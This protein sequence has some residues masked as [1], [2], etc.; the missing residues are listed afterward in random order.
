VNRKLATGLQIVFGFV[1]GTALNVVIVWAGF[2]ASSLITGNVALDQTGTYGLV[3]IG[4]SQLIWQV[5]VILILRRK[6]H[7]ALALG[8][9]LAASVTAL[10]NATCWGLMWSGKIK[11]GG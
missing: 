4:V 8:V 3:F 10:L 6:Q 11:I 7:K 1:L 2:L 9:I 5:P